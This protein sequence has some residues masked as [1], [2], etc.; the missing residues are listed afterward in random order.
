MPL[1][2]ADVLTGLQTGLIDSIG[3]PP[4]GAI[5]LQWHTQI[6]HVIDI[7]VMYVYGLFA[8][9]QRPFNRLT[10]R[11]KAIV[12]SE[13]SQ[14]VKAADGFARRDHQSA[15]AALINQDG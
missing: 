4:I 10:E 13:L 12:S 8:I 2:L 14:A 3:S 1:P 5:V 6:E 9:A 15:K 11:Q 7:P